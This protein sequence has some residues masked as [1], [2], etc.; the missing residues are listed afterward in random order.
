[1]VK[2]IMKDR[3]ECSVW[4]NGSGSW[5]IRILGGTQVRDAHFRRD[6]SPVIVEIDGRDYKFNVDK[7][8]FWT[9]TCGELIGV[10]VKDWK[11][12]H[13]LRSGDH[14]WLRILVPYQRFR[15]EAGEKKGE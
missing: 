8:S 14:A 4:T 10:A 12:R 13:G 5:G 2:G 11:T 1:M 15:L 3:L 7:K 9:R 6:L